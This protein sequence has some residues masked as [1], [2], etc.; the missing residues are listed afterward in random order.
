MPLCLPH[1]ALY[2]SFDRYPSFKGAAAHIFRMAGTLF[3]VMDGGLLYVLGDETLPFYQK[4]GNTEILRFSFPVP[5][6][7]ERTVAFGKRLSLLVRE[8]G[9]SLK[10][11]HFRDPWS[12]IPILENKKQSCF[13][14]YEING[15]PSIELPFAYPQVSPPTLKKIRDMEEFCWTNSNLIITPS[16]SIKNNL[17]ILGVPERKI[18]VVPNGADLKEKKP[19][20]RGAP[21]R[22]L[23]YVGAV[24]KWQGIEILLRAFA[25]LKDFPDLHLVFCL[26]THKKKS[27]LYKKL[28]RKLEINDRVIWK[29]QFSKEKLFAWISNALLSMAPLTE[30]S[31]NLS[32]GCCPLKILE[33]MACG[34]PVVASDLPSVRELVSD[35]INGR[36][37]IP[38]RP[39]ELARAVRLLLDYPEQIRKLGKQARQ[40]VQDHFTWEKSMAGL[41]EHYLSLLKNGKREFP[42]SHKKRKTRTPVKEVIQ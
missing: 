1:K 42:L 40:H 4:E 31:R 25:R 34:T 3:K 11:C 6:F 17:I 37:V 21:R 7:L 41:Q 35:E 26:S 29:Q 8:H 9:D 2:A 19:R 5:N 13:S 15:L 39:Q 27:V 23:I 18:R 38:D 30:C 12:G 28:A 20:P 10:I 32:Q 33:S 24:Q 14:V 22:Y 36:L 16:L